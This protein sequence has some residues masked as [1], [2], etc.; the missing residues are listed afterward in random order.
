[1]PVQAAHAEWVLPWLVASKVSPGPVSIK[2]Y[3][4]FKKVLQLN[5]L[6]RKDFFPNAHARAINSKPRFLGGN[7]FS[8]FIKLF[9]PFVFR[10]SRGSLP[11]DLGLSGKRP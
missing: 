4:I 6:V 11:R 8:C 2:L 9:L 5:L 1:M 10:L 7:E 3:N